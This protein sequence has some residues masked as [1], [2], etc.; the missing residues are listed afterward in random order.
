LSHAKALK[1]KAL[2]GLP[3]KKAK[4]YFLMNQRLTRAMAFVAQWQPQYQTPQALTQ[5][6]CISNWGSA[7]SGAKTC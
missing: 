4:F 5:I 3:T 1:I 7:K 6:L 2:A